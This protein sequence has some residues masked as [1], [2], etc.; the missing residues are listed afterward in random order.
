MFVY[1]DGR[2]MTVEETKA[3]L[4]DELEQGHTVIPYGD[5]DNF[6]YKTGCM[7]HEN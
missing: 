4:L 2:P 7:G 3:V 1:E 6:D 5:C